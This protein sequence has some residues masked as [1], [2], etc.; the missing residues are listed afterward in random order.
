MTFFNIK[1]KQGKYIIV[2][3]VLIRLHEYLISFYMYR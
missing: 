2:K 3:V 1:I